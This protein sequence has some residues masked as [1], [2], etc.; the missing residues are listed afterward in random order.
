MRSERTNAASGART[1]SGCLVIRK[2]VSDEYT[3]PVRLRFTWA[4]RL[5]TISAATRPW[6]APERDIFRH[7]PPTKSYLPPAARKQS[8]PAADRQ[9]N[10]DMD[11]I[12]PPV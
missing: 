9:V 4:M 2:P 5:P 6:R 7:P 8:N 3:A 11:Q 12:H 1:V 10:D